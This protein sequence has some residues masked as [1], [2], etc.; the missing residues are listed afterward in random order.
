VAHAILAGDAETGV[1]LMEGTPALDAGPIIVQESTPVGPSETAGELTDRLARAGGAL[2]ESTLP[3]YIAGKLRGEPQDE[4]RVTWAPKVRPA[5]AA[6]DFARP[7][8]ELER[9]I[10]AFTPDPGAWTTVRGARLVVERAAAAGGHAPERGALELRDG[11]PHIAAGAG[12]LRLE[13]VRPAGRRSMAAADWA[14]GLRGVAGQR[15]PS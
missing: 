11:V 10:R 7:A 8:E 2:L 3:R 14:R 1:T 13:R 12:W 4:S 6:L 15:L 9:W 5:D